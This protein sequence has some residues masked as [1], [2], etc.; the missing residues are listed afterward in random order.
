MKS[1]KISRKLL[2]KDRLASTHV[3]AKHKLCRTNAT[4]LDPIIYSTKYH[5]VHQMITLL[6]SP[7]S[8]S[9][10]SII[11]DHNEQS[12]GWCKY[13]CRSIDSIHEASSIRVRILPCHVWRKAGV[14][15]VQCTACSYYFL[16]Y[17]IWKLYSIDRILSIIGSYLS[18]ISM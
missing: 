6:W 7:C 8:Q 2:S 1:R 16:V 9:H 3:A 14:Y 5:P 17:D 10:I 4:W 15:S 18:S 13:R 12:I 11:I